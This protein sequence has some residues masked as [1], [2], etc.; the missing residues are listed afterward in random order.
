MVHLWLL[1]A[2]VLIAAPSFVSVS[3]DSGGSFLWNPPW[4]NEANVY[5]RMIKLQHAGDR[6]GKLLATWEHWY[7]KRQG[8]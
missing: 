7:T 4:F 5:A 6:N 1:V 3:A 8:Q 2:Q